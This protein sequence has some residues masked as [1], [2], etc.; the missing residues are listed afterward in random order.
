M[1]VHRNSE[2]NL[3]VRVY[4]LTINWGMRERKKLIVSDTSG[5]E[6]V[7]PLK[8]EQIHRAHKRTR[9]WALATLWHPR[10]A[11]VIKRGL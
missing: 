1:T 7:E 2:N 6:S 8:N 11:V 10:S 4:G 5:K 9:I 3:T